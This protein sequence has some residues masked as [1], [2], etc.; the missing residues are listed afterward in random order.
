MSKKGRKIDENDPFRYVIYIGP[1]TEESTN[2]RDLILCLKR[3]MPVFDYITIPYYGKHWRR[4]L[5]L[6]NIIIRL[7]LIRLFTHKKI[8]Q[9]FGSDGCNWDIKSAIM[10]WAKRFGYKTIYQS[11]GGTYQQFTEYRNSKQLSDDLNDIDLVLIPSGI[12][13]RWFIQN[14]NINNSRVMRTMIEKPSDEEKMEPSPIPVALFTGMFTN[15]KG[16]FDI[17]ECVA[18]YHEKLKGKIKVLMVGHGDG[19]RLRQAVTDK[20]VDDIIDVLGWLNDANKAFLIT[21][22]D[23][24]ILMSYHELMPVNAVEAMLAGLAVIATPVGAVPELVEDGKTGFIVP[25]GDIDALYGALE[26]Y[27]R[28]PRL[29]KEHGQAAAEKLSDFLPQAVIARYRKF[30]HELLDNNTKETDESDSNDRSGGGEK[31]D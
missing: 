28:S 13:Q 30:Y 20:G 22:S 31:P 17:V 2:L 10:R 27:I 29:L 12:R 14:F 4:W 16:V 5:S 15:E 7:G 18:K 9:L 1:S 6:W 25:E 3:N 8:A 21:G 11:L 19:A 24:F 26:T 23:L